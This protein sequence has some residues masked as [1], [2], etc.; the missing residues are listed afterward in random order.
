M[1]GQGWGNEKRVR[2][3][4]VRGG[5]VRKGSG[6]GVGRGGEVRKGSGLWWKGVKWL[7]KGQGWGGKGWSSEKRV[8]VRVV[9]GGVVRKGSWLG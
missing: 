4:V 9:R 8:M 2:V 7:E 6:F 1:K 3:G 5:M